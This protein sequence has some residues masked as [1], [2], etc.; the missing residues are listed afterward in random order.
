MVGFHQYVIMNSVTSSLPQC[1]YI[2]AEP[3]L[4][5]ITDEHLIHRT[6]NK[7]D[8][9]RLDVAV[10]N[11]WGND[12]QRALNF[13]NIRVFNPLIRTPLWPN[14]TEGKETCLRPTSERN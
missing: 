7:E 11:F 10:D 1:W 3:S 4:Q 14:A 6:A 12:R 8:G 2:H 5:P 13:F 9:A